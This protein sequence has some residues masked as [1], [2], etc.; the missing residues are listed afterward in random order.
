M[1]WAQQYRFEAIV[2]TKDLLSVPGL[3]GAEVVDFQLGYEFDSEV[4]EGVGYSVGFS[5]RLLKNAVKAN[6]GA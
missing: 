2:Q 6:Q 3:F 1:R 5:G 4:A